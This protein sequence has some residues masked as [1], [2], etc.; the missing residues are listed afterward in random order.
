MPLNPDLSTV[1]GEER[2][3][4]Q[5]PVGLLKPL[6]FSRAIPRLFLVQFIPSPSTFVRRTPLVSV[7]RDS[8]RIPPSE[9]PS[10]S[11]DALERVRA[12]SGTRSSIG[13]FFPFGQEPLQLGIF[14][15]SVCWRPTRLAES[16]LVLTRSLPDPRPEADPGGFGFWSK[17]SFP[18]L[19]SLFFDFL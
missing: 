6:W 16:L 7:S 2:L 17:L 18:V 13:R 1:V 9:F 12:R 10:S 5:V 3:A 14:L 19:I 8:R 4:V 15:R 11:A